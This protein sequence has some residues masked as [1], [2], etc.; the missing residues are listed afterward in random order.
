MS[1][2]KFITSAFDGHQ[3]QYNFTDDNSYITILKKDI[4]HFLQDYIVWIFLS[5]FLLQDLYLSVF[6][7]S[8]L[9]QM[10]SAILNT[11]N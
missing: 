7:T 4:C 3:N 6:K 2:I 11:F 10:L 1:T 5:F 9:Q 8:V